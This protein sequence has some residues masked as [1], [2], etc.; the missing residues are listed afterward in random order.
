[1]AIP[2]CE[3]RAAG[4]CGRSFLPRTG[5]LRSDSLDIRSRKEVRCPALLFRRF[6]L[7][8]CDTVRRE[9]SYHVFLGVNPTLTLV[10]KSD[11]RGGVEGTRVTL[12]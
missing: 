11:S 10:A 12:R 7:G 6:S 5:F 9:V 4:Q 8:E 3:L 2:G 1:M